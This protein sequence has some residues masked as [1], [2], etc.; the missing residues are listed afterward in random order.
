MRERGPD[1]IAGQVFHSLFFSW[2]GFGGRR[3]PENRNVSRISTFLK[4]RYRQSDQSLKQ[5]VIYA[6]HSIP[7]GKTSLTVSEVGFGGIPII[8]LDEGT[9]VTVLRRAY[10]SGITLYDTANIYVDSEKK[11]GRALGEGA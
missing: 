7:L 10:E 2:D 9:A 11:I 6:I 8:W 3:R 5:K 1:D 4:R